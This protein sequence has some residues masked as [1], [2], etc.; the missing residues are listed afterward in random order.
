[1]CNFVF[2]QVLALS[3]GF[4]YVYFHL[5]V[6][7][8]LVRSE[9]LEVGLPFSRTLSPLFLDLLLPFFWGGVPTFP[10]FEFSHL[11]VFCTKKFFDSIPYSLLTHFV[12]LFFE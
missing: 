3:R 7:H 12:R 10:S 4:F 2:G 5:A 1:V 11:L 6:S 8:L 9:F